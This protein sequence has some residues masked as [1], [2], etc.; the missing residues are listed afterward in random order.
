V[1]TVNI[2]TITIERMF[3]ASRRG[4]EKPGNAATMNRPPASSDLDIESWE[5]DST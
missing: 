3:L 4:P 5:H 1:S 2:N